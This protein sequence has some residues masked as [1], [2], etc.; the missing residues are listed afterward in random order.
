MTATRSIRRRRSSTSAWPRARRRP[1]PATRP[2]ASPR[3]R[4][5]R[6][7]R[8]RRPE[9]FSAASSTRARTSSPAH[10]HVP[11]ARRALPVSRN[12]D[13]ADVGDAT[14][15][16]TRKAGLPSARSLKSVIPGPWTRSS[17]WPSASGRRSA[18]RAPSTC[19]GTCSGRAILRLTPKLTPAVKPGASAA[20]ARHGA[21]ADG[22]A[23]RGSRG[24]AAAA[25]AAGSAD[26]GSPTPSPAMGPAGMQSVQNWLVATA[27]GRPLDRVESGAELLHPGQVR[28]GRALVGHRL[29]SVIIALASRGGGSRRCS[30]RQ[31]LRRLGSPGNVHDGGD[32]RIGR[33]G[34]AGGGRCGAG[35]ARSGRARGGGRSSSEAGVAAAVD[36]L[37]PEGPQVTISMEGVP[38]G[39]RSGSTASR[40]STACRRGAIGTEAGDHHG[41]RRGLL[42]LRDELLPVA[43]TIFFVRDGAEAVADADAGRAG[44]DAGT[45]GRCAREVTTLRRDGGTTVRRDGDTT[46]VRREASRRAATAASASSGTTSSG[47]RGGRDSPHT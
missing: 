16:G 10:D 12:E 7:C 45:R 37:P 34:P 21:D 5:A 27:A 31:G 14:P 42:E 2:A 24:G 8:L 18:T 32:S 20:A 25:A 43:D 47:G 29:L 11:R 40:S 19:S 9:M 30:P 6:A 44:R 39:P 15:S 41:P 35:R 38:D 28:R 1:A 4:G 22:D 3:R 36:A 33:C 26:S 13:R 46:T 23:G 17:R